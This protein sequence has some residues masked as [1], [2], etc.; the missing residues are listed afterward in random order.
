MLNQLY[1]YFYD[2]LQI[3]NFNSLNIQQCHIILFHVI[4][5]NWK[6]FL[7]IQ[8]AC[9]ITLCLIIFLYWKIILKIQ[10]NHLMPHHLSLLKNNSENSRSMPHHLMP[11]HISP[12]KNNYENSRKSPHPT[13]HSS[14]KNNSKNSR[15]CIITH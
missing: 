1:L 10:E 8:L 3:I 4:F 2:P 12:L 5:L 7:K 14:L 15:K 13:S 9:H 6:I 11:H